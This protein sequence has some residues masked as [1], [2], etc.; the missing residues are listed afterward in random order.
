MFGDRKVEMI[1]GIPYT[2]G[3]NPPHVFTVLR[4]AKLF[5]ERFSDADW[6]VAEEKMIEIGGSCPIP[7]LLVLT[8]PMEAYQARKIEAADILLLVEFCD[9]SW[10]RDVK[11]KL[12]VYAEAG[13]PECWFVRLKR[14]SLFRYTE[15]SG[16]LYRQ[17]TIFEET[18]RVPV[19]DGS[20]LVS[21]FL[22]RPV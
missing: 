5:R 10:A 6:T 3:T 2:M 1:R 18:D 19:G 15:P 21:D 14:R 7:D 17:Q 13:I 11:K 9:S 22:P 4:L 20:L 12:P 8:R 16:L